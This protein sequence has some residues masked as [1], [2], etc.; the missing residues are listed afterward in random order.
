MVKSV[1]HITKKRREK[2][3]KIVIELRRGRINEEYQKITKKHHMEL[4]SLS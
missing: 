4:L 3:E 1:A 2:V